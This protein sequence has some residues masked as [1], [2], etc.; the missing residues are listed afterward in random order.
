LLTDVVDEIAVNT[1]DKI[2]DGDGA[3][4]KGNGAIFTFVDR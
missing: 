1:P 2:A 4:I 3:M